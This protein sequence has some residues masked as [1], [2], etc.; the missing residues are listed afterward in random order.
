MVT[1]TTI[2]DINWIARARARTDKRS[3][4]YDVMG[5]FDTSGGVYLAS[6][7]LWFNRFPLDPDQKRGLAVRIESFRN[8]DHLGAVNELAWW[9]F[10]QREQFN[11]NPIPTASSPTPDFQVLTP[12]EFFIEVSTLNVSERDKSKFEAGDSVELDHDETLRRILGKL[13]TEKKKQLSY[14][15]E[16]K[17]PTVLVLFDY[18]T[19]SAFGTQFYRFLADFLLGKPRGFQNLPVE[20]SALVYVERTVFD[21]HIAISRLRS[22]AYYSPYAKHPLPGGMFPSMNQFSWQIVAVE[23]TSPESWVWL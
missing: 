13:T 12:S 22:A 8:E 11:A 3:W 7:R 19:W 21:G 14:A 17:K 2:F 5:D 23:S 9:R 20:L 6:L 15:A 10:L 16:L 1:R 4:V 18:T